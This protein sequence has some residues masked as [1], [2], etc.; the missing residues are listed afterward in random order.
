MFVHVLARLAFL[1]FSRLAKRKRKRL[2]PRLF[3]Y[4]RLK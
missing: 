2:L 4:Y 3:Y 1:R